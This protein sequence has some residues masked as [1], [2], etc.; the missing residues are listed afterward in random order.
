M[1][2]ISAALPVFIISI[3]VADGIHIFSEFKDHLLS[4]LS[5]KEALRQTMD[6]LFI[7]VVMTSVTTASAFI[8][9]S[10][11]EIIQLRHFGFF[12]AVGTICAMFLSLML[13][14]AML[15]VAPVKQASLAKKRK[16]AKPVV[17]H[18]LHTFLKKISQASINSPRWVLAC[19]ALI[20]IVAA[21]AASK[22]RIDNNDIEYHLDDSPLVVSTHK[23]N[24]VAAGS[25]VLNVLLHSANPPEESFLYPE[26]LN[27]VNDLASFIE[28]HPSVGKVNGLH[29]LVKRINYV[30]HDENPEFDRLP[31][32]ME[33]VGEEKTV[34]G[35]SMISQFILLYDM[36]GGDTLS[37]VVESNY[38]AMNMP[39][40]LKVNSSRE[41]DALMDD[42]KDYCKSHLPGHMSI[43]FSGSA[44]VTV[45]ATSE[46]VKGQIISLLISFVLIMI[47]LIYTFRSLKIGLAA[48]LPLVITILINFGIMGVL[49]ISLDIGTAVISSIV[50]GIGV[51]YS[52]HYI[53]RFLE[54]RNRGDAFAQAIDR[55]VY[56]SGKAILAN[57]VTVG[58]G[59][60]ALLFSTLTP[61]ITM[62]WMITA[63]MLISAF[64]T[65]IILPAAITLLSAE[66]QEDQ[67]QAM[68]ADDISCTAV[69]G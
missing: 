27:I 3:G 20:M 59:F 31:E 21:V 56:H 33:K 69:S 57:A 25:S 51:D 65:L 49:G 35:Y 12:V 34:S 64:S 23:M 41:I 50:I 58:T 48:M 22:V 7:P 45:A 4:G 53:K 13:I 6:E 9:L 68:A 15:Q 10:V 44:A 36:G 11:T 61:L 17:D 14:P 40:I 16:S 32:P 37:D 28:K 52:I 60:I 1:N 46:I 43:T 55:T 63:T 39:V 42:I 30:L 18:F 19:S 62:G 24:D 5:K 29:E 67:S 66:S 2:I 47:I 26:N 8:A 54:F 38:N